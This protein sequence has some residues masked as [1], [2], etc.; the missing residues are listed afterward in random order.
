MAAALTGQSLSAVVDAVRARF[1]QLVNAK[2][3]GIAFDLV[4]GADD[5]DA[6]KMLDELKPYLAGK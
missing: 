4:T 5:E 1:I 6:V 2:I 3:G